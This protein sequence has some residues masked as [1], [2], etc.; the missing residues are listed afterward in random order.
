MKEIFYF[1]FV[2][3]SMIGYVVLISYE[4]LHLYNLHKLEYRQYL[5]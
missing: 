5:L 2:I 3:L 4:D 1:D